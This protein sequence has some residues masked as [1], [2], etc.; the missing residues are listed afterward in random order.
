MTT[1]PPKRNSRQTWRA[2][3]KQLPAQ[4]NVSRIFA[5]PQRSTPSTSATS[6]LESKLPPLSELP[7]T[8]EETRR[9]KRERDPSPMNQT[10]TAGDGASCQGGSPAAEPPLERQYSNKRVKRSADVPESTGNT[11][12][13]IRRTRS[14]MSGGWFSQRSRERPSKPKSV[15]EQVESAMV[16]SQS[17]TS[18]QRQPPEVSQPTPA[19]TPATQTPS[20][21]TPVTSGSQ[22]EPVGVPLKVAT[23]SNSALSSSPAHGRWLGSLRRVPSQPAKLQEP[24][25]STMSAVAQEPTHMDLDPPATLPARV[26][27]SNPPTR[28]GWFSKSSSSSPAPIQQPLPDRSIPPS[29]IP[30]LRVIEPAPTPSSAETAPATVTVN[31][32]AARHML[33]IP[34]LGRPKMKA[35]EL[36]VAE[37]L[38][39]PLLLI[40]VCYTNTKFNT[41]SHHNTSSTVSQR[42]S[43]NPA[44]TSESAVRDSERACSFVR[45]SRMVGVHRSWIWCRTE[46]DRGR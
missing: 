16:S 28:T 18:L 10:V 35:Q 27:S 46:S 12:S 15:S 30:S 7:E 37:G 29:P 17:T 39:T 36:V 31:T 45:P 20:S 26:P 3:S 38:G 5:E 42:W 43:A 22:V 41:S 4:I 13:T 32:A 8:T 24:Q 19:A 14:L 44:L 34:F 6:V 9:P 11:E 40:L 21:T 33:N 25:P 1:P 2:P 23:K